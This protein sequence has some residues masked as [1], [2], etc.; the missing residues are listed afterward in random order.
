MVYHSPIISSYIVRRVIHVHVRTIKRIRGK[1]KA[2][3]LQVTCPHQSENL[4]KKTV[5]YKRRGKRISGNRAIEIIASDLNANKA[6]TDPT[7]EIPTFDPVTKT[8]NRFDKNTAN[9]YFF[10]AVKVDSA[11]Q[12]IKDIELQPVEGGGS[13]EPMYFRFVS[14]YDHSTGN[15]LDIVLVQ[16]FEQGYQDDG[17][18]NFVNIPNVT[19]THPKLGSGNRS[20]FIAASL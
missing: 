7:I 5:S 20:A 3:S 1:G 12:E 9:N 14:K 13:F 4:W 17:G 2:L 16:A 15:F 10:D 8:G 18:G 19:L 6:S 11:I